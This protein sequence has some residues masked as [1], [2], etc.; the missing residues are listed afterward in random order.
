M[1]DKVMRPCRAP[2][3]AIDRSRTA[4]GNVNS[5]QERQEVTS[6]VLSIE[7]QEDTDLGVIW[8][9]FRIP[10]TQHPEGSHAQEI[11]E[12]GEERDE[13]IDRE[14]MVRPGNGC[15]LTLAMVDAAADEGAHLVRL[16]LPREASLDGKMAASDAGSLY[17]NYRDQQICQIKKI[18]GL[19][20]WHRNNDVWQNSR[21]VEIDDI[22]LDA[23]SSDD[24]LPIAGTL[25]KKIPKVRAKKKRKELWTYE[26]VAEPTVPVIDPTIAKTS[27]D[28]R[29][30][31][32]IQILKYGL[33][34][35]LWK[36]LGWLFDLL[37]R[38]G[39]VDGSKQ[40]R[41]EICW[42]YYK[43][44]MLYILAETTT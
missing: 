13:R 10:E 2:R 9:T 15:R 29:R 33:S 4:T 18:G 19:Q 3:V 34:H 21:L 20:S 35:N 36:K 30:L 8:E 44:Q 22:L 31:S 40:S 25:K 27:T 26:A 24:D 6:D 39:I 42:Q 1:K 32:S 37:N 14:E 11:L 41:K 38:E 17:Y 43:S 7:S 12:T 5:D 23:S 28:F 16:A